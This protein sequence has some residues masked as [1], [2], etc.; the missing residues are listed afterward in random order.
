MPLECWKRRAKTSASRVGQRNGT[1]MT[2]MQAVQSVA[3]SGPET[4]RRISRGFMS[5]NDLTVRK[6]MMME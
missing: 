4:Q 5:I 6:W 2:Q 3:R 1:S